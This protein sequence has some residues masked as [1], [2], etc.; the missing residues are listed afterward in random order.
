MI[1]PTV[2]SARPANLVSGVYGGNA[3]PDQGV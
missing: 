1:L 3:Q 2:L